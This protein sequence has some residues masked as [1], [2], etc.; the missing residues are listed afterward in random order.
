MLVVSEDEDEDESSPSTIQPASQSTDQP[1]TQS[2][3]TTAGTSG[4]QVPKKKGKKGASIDDVMATIAE[5]IEGSERL[6]R[7]VDELIQVESKSQ[8]A[9]AHWMGTEMNTIHDDL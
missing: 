5:K 1:T 7:R 3:G 8:T 4:T 2:T 6:E 9:W